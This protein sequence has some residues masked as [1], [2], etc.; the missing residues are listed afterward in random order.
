MHA[1]P[2]SATAFAVDDADAQDAALAAFGEVFGEQ[3][4]DFIG[5]EGVQV[6]FRA[7]G[8]LHQLGN[9]FVIGLRH[10]RSVRIEM[11]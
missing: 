3:A 11:D 2:E 9:R 4:A 7:D 10:G 6:E 8:V 5:P 1:G